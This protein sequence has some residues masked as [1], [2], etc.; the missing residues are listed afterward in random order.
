M[1]ATWTRHPVLAG[2]VGVLAGAL[3]IALTEWLAHQWLGK[4][5]LA[6]PANDHPSDVRLGA[7]ALGYWAPARPPTWPRP[8]E[9]G[10]ACSPGLIASGVL[11]AGSVSH[12]ARAPAP[13]SGW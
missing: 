7:R 1:P 8:G 9:A 2:I 10:A 12:L 6:Q 4:A 5:D 11:L 3:A 13:S